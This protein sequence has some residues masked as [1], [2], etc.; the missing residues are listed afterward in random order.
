VN[1]NQTPHRLRYERHEQQRIPNMQGEKKPLI[2]TSGFFS[3]PK[4]QSAHQAA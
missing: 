1:S 3:Q 2:A 4:L